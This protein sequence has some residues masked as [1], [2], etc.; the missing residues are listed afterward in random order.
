MTD[1][2]K[3]QRA[4]KL[5]PI[6]DCFSGVLPFY[7]T[8]DTLFLSIQKGLSP[9]Q[10]SLLLFIISIA[11]F[12][13]E[14]PSFAIIRK[15]GNSRSAVI[16]GIFP[17]IGMVILL[18]SNSFW[19]MAVAFSFTTIA[20]NF[21]NIVSG[22]IRNNMELIGRR[23]EFTKVNSRGTFLFS[24]ITPI[25][26]TVAVAAYK[27]NPYIPLFLCLAVCIFEAV[28]SFFMKDYSEESTHK[29]VPTE[30]KKK[31]G[32]ISLNPAM[33]FLLI[34]FCLIFCTLAS[35]TENA[36]LIIQG[37]L[38]RSVGADMCVT[39]FGILIFV[40]QIVRIIANYLFPKMFERFKTSFIVVAVGILFAAFAMAGFTATAIESEWEVVVLFSISYLLVVLVRLPIRTYFR[41][42][43]VDTNDKNLQRFMLLGLDFGQSVVSIVISGAATLVISKF[44][45]NSSMLL[46]ALIIAVA[47]FCTLLFAGAM[48]KGSSL[49]KLSYSLELNT[50]DI[51][52]ERIAEF[53]NLMKLSSEVITS[54]RL[55]A[56]EILL[57]NLE[58]GKAGEEVNLDITAQNGNLSMNI[59]V[60]GEKAEDICM[61]DIKNLRYWMNPMSR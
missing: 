58:N 42:T 7:I 44:G 30:K 32:H 56:E 52:S 31:I 43:A 53:G 16:G 12:I 57:Q 14:I 17:V 27:L 38:T 28:L 10:M 3:I 46:F 49:L 18:V 39:A 21:Q 34:A 20:C 50:V 29:A 51:V 54:Y 4:I 24:V 40:S 5:Y 61:A 11:D 41:T 48:K 15:L 25:T 23:E 60:A 13:S 8:V 26:S 59:T 2:R 6:F 55:L 45:L 22:S 9:T 33:L 35:W 19:Q 47:F 36:E 1:T 37:N